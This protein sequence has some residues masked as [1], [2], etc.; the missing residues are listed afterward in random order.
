MVALTRSGRQA[1]ALRSY[2]A[3]RTV[4]GEELGLEP[5]QELRE[6]EAAI[7][8]QHEDL[9]RPDAHAGAPLYR[10]NLRSPLTTLV[11]RQ[12]DL[13]ALRSFW[14]AYRLVTLVGAGGVGKSRLAIEAA[15]QMF[16]TAAAD[17]WLVE[18]AEVADPDELVPAIM[19]ALDV[20]K[21]GASPADARRLIDYLKVRQ[22]LLILDNCEHLV[23]TVAQLAQ[24]LL[25]SCPDLKIW[26]TS[27]EGL[28]VTGEVLWPVAPLSLDEAIT[29]FVERGRAADP[30]V[31]FG[32]AGMR[33]TGAVE[34]ICVR[35]DGLPLAIELAA[36]RLRAMPITELAAGLED[37]FRVLNR[38]ARTALPRQQTLR[39]VVDWSY[40]LLFDDER[41]VFDRL[42]V[43]GGTC[44]L[45]AARAICA[46]DDITNDDVAELVSRLA[47]KSLVVVESDEIEGYARC[48]MLQT[49]VD[50][51]RERLDASGE[52]TRMFAAHMHYY[53]DFSIRSGG[54]LRGERQRGW[55]R[56]VTANLGNLRSAF[57]A[58]IADG[59]AETA[60]SIA[61]GIGWY[62]V[63]TG[64]TLEGAQWLNQARHCAGP[65]RD[66]TGARLLA[67][68]A[69]TDAPLFVPAV[70]PDGARPSNE[71]ASSLD[72]MDNEI[73]SPGSEVIARYRADGAFADLAG[74]EVV[75]AV[76]HS[77]RG[78][79]V[80]AM[81][82]L[83]DAEQALEN[84]DPAPHVT[85]MQT[86][87]RARRL[88]IDNQ[89]PA[90]DEAFRTAVEQLE[91][92][93]V[94][95][96]CALR[97][98]TSADSPGCAAT[99]AAGAEAI[100]RSLIAARGLGLTGFANVLATD[101]AECLAAVG[102]FERARDVLRQRLAGARD[103]AYLPGI[104][105]TLA[106]LAAVEWHADEYERAVAVAEEALDIAI[107][108]DSVEA[109]GLCLT[110]LGLVAA[111]GGDA[112]R[113]ACPSPPWTR[114]RRSRGR[115]ADRCARTRGPR[116][117]CDARRGRPDGGATARCR[118]WAQA[119]TRER[120]RLS[121]R[122]E[123]L[124]RR[125]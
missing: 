87:V 10:T 96:H 88:L 21:T 23:A 22:S 76:A 125:R 36:A 80:R 68:I 5:S 61:G 110:I 112:R 73:D 1:D 120:G 31:D 123:H 38:G 107:S 47:D 7:L 111:R 13:E 9:T 102:D 67:W 42:S 94:E 37:R 26:A 77:T 53:A 33:A 92:A 20:E 51:G 4:L 117:R 71:R 89:V 83:A 95:V 72:F 54:A 62:W 70:R 85:A 84:V 122:R 50:Y 32:G 93:G 55:L 64:R 8:Q 66:I 79:F 103:V 74:I 35:L 14:P 60:Q 29:L 119:N 97:S 118:Q 75:L 39:A 81:E 24:D 18:L 19:Q 78:E 106:A 27:R 59:D 34:E 90:A 28:A 86:F 108:I 65:V 101:L 99:G 104:A 100:E 25:E 40:E 11:G 46:D 43:F 105:D 114:T 44:T 82:L 116:R 124:R 57:D 113:G 52:A 2:Q 30:T 56:A 3:A 121:L 58:A 48:H 6:L 12:R 41:R 63:F 45:A 98:A 16:D 17:V 115:P 109:A 69:V 49:L 91:A 15:R